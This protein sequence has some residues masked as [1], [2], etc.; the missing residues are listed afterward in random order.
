MGRLCF[1]T[2]FRGG[3]LTKWPKARPPGKAGYYWDCC[4]YMDIYRIQDQ[5]GN[6]SN[7]ITPLGTSL[8]ISFLSLLQL[9]LT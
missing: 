8:F 4:P 9:L 5:V 6:P 2:Q 3:V 7:I 1:N